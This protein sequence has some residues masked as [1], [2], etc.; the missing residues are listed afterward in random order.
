[1]TRQLDRTPEDIRLH[2]E[3]EKELADRLRN[4]SRAERNKLYTQ[5]Y[6]ELFRRV[7]NHPQLSADPISRRKETLNQVSMLRHFLKPGMV[8]LEVG[9]GDLA[10]SIEASKHVKEA[11]AVEA[12]EQVTT[13]TE[14]PDNFHVILSN[15]CDI[16]LPGNSVDY[17]YSNQFLEHLHP[18][19][20]IDH[21]RSVHA[22]LKTGGGYLCITPSRI[23]GPHDISKYF[24]ENATGLHL[25][26]Y[27]LTELSGLFCACGF[28]GTK[29]VYG[30][31]GSF[32][33]LP[34]ETVMFL[35]KALSKVPA[36][37]R[38][39]IA[40]FLPV[41]MLLGVKLVAVK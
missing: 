40:S 29:A 14:Y 25:H 30:Y 18:E 17:V 10:L 41:R 16:N 38:K 28:S 27:T 8:F 12:S 36:A 23:N 35:E 26:E 15:A 34:P 11:Y 21:L 7:P 33:L 3:V 4:S 32:I 2:Y 13:H 31:G 37:M 9:A 24:D 22:L 1:M 6:D 20:A 39:R 5:V 19:D